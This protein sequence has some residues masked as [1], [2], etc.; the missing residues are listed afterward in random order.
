MNNLTELNINKIE[1]KLEEFIDYVNNHWI[2]NCAYKE[3]TKYHYQHRKS[4]VESLEELKSNGDY[5]FISFFM[6]SFETTLLYREN[7]FNHIVLNVRLNEIKRDSY[8]HQLYDSDW[9]EI[10]HSLMKYYVMFNMISELN[11]YFS[12]ELFE[13]YEFEITNLFVDYLAKDIRK[14][15]YDSEVKKTGVKFDKDSKNLWIQFL[16]DI[17]GVTKGE[18]RK[19]YNSDRRHD[20]SNSY[21]VKP[22]DVQEKPEK[23]NPLLEKQIADLYFHVMYDRNNSVESRITEFLEVFKYEGLFRYCIYYLEPLMHVF[24]ELVKEHLIKKINQ[25]SDSK[26]LDIIMLPFVSHIGEIEEGRGLWFS[27]T[28]KNG[29]RYQSRRHY[30]EDLFYLVEYSKKSMWYKEKNRILKFIGNN[31]NK[32]SR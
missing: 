27:I 30:E 29:E 8:K 13:K 18:F 1:N 32:L 16:T 4:I 12:N 23:I 6:S 14:M 15:Y 31:P 3:V 7:M 24:L 9:N 22:E 5:I 10:Y 25:Y 28:K 21:N 26:D 11:S 19:Y 17:D 20:I 2:Q